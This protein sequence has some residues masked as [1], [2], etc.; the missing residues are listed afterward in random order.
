[1]ISLAS[2]FFSIPASP[3]PLISGSHL[4]L[5][6]VHNQRVFFNVSIWQ[7]SSLAPNLP[8]LPTAHR[9]EPWPFN[10]ALEAFNLA[11]AH[12]ASPCVL[13]SNGDLSE[14]IYRGFFFPPGLV[15]LAKIPSDP[16]HPPSQVSPVAPYM[17]QSKCGAGTA[18]RCTGQIA[19]PGPLC[20][21]FGEDPSPYWPSVY[22]LNNAGI[23]DG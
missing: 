20:L 3:V 21:G 14:D 9:T 7:C 23:R 10:L 13:W 4:L 5:S 8:W 17:Q 12:T 16:G 15:Q 2:P 11:P 6:P 22:P 1:M 19:G 18:V